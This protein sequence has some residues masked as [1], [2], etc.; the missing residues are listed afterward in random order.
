MKLRR[1]LVPSLGVAIWLAI[2]LGQSLSDWRQVL[3]SADGDACLHRRIGEWM[4][5]HRAVLRTEQFSHTRFGAP[6]IAKE[7]LSEIAYAAAERA[8]GW[9]GAVLIAALLI[10]TTLWLLHRWLLAEGCELLLATGLVLLAAL[11][12]SHHWL[13][14]PH[15]VTPLFALLFA[16]QLRV[17]DRAHEP[18]PAR[19]FLILVPAMWLWSNLHGAFFT[20]FVLI[21]VYA[22]GNL[23]RPGKAMP[24]AALGVAC[25]LVS[26][27]NPNG[28]RL[29][30]HI[31]EFLREPVIAKFA[32]EFR[33]PNF[34][35]GAMRGFLLQLLVLGAVLGAARSRWRGV[36]VIL[37]L[38]WGYFALQAVR[39]IPIFAIIV[40]PMLAEH[41]SRYFREARETG[42]LG[43]YRRVSGNL[44]GLDRAAGG[45]ALVAVAIVA[46]IFAQ[47]RGAIATD[48]LPERFPVAAVQW[49]RAHP[50]SVRGEM[51]NDYAWGGYLMLAL[52]ERRVFVD[53]RNDFYGPALIEEFNKADDAAPGW[54]EVLRKYDVGWTILPVA[55]RLNALLALEAGWKRVYADD[56]VAIY[57]R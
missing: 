5:E 9:N 8:L 29:H 21:G 2:F 36:D 1:W 20:G 38:V 37:V 26:F 17:F 44:T 15:L 28:W 47:A 3:I 55:H 39:N 53:G 57:S 32:N 48:V 40:T 30:T 24:F 11:A 22:A 6:V 41:W 23:T 16:W 35:S 19:L 31:V 13:A 10:A 18:R 51:F 27:L 4:I 43:A 50:D 7:W 45:G 46:V 52:A 54:D 49:L 14:R 34:H 25:L 33:S 12:S 56:V 42:W